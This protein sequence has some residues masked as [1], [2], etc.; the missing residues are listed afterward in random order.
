M[1]LVSTINEKIHV[2]GSY[3]VWFIAIFVAA[4]AVVHWLWSPVMGFTDLWLWETYVKISVPQF[5][6]I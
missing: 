4:A 5:P 1:G 2:K 3:S 6:H